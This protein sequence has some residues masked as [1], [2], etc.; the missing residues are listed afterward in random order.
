MHK[1]G[2]KTAIVQPGFKNEIP[3]PNASMASWVIGTLLQGVVCFG[4]TFVVRKFCTFDLPWT[5]VD[6]QKQVKENQHYTYI[7]QM[8]KQGLKWA[9]VISF[10]W[11]IIPCIKTQR[12]VRN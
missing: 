6:F 2:G 4:F 10:P 1:I 5:T 8:G 11:S 12:K 7:L 3:S 9:E